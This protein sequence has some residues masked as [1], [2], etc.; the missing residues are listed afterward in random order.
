MKSQKPTFKSQLCKPGKFTSSLCTMDKLICGVS[1]QYYYHVPGTLGRA[2]YQQSSYFVSS[3]INYCLPLLFQES[4]SAPH[5]GLG[6]WLGEGKRLLRALSKR[7]YNEGPSRLEIWTSPFS[8]PPVPPR[9]SHLASSHP[10]PSSM[11]SGRTRVHMATQR[12]SA[13]HLQALPTLSVLLAGPCPQPLPHPLSHC[14]HSH[15]VD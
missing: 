13:L 11:G 7:R 4:A 6:D 3:H 5:W 10:P 2:C 15:S 9:R 1:R 12:G 8:G 14:Q